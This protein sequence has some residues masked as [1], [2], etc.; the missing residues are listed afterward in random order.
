MAKIALAI[1]IGIL[2]A[3]TGGLAAAGYGIFAGTFA[4]GSVLGGI[5]LGGSIGLSVGQLAGGLLFPG[6][7]NVAGP[8]LSDGQISS[9]ANGLPIP[10]GYG[11]F[12]IGAQIIWSG[13]I[14]ETKT[15]TTQSAKGGP[16]QTST[17]YSYTVSFAA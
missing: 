1:G 8:R 5:A 13:G 17:T 2:G 11:G 15:T 12:R 14:K 9:S 7:S 3:V 4:G 16:S 10:F 6:H